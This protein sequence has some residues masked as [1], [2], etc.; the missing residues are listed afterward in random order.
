MSNKDYAPNNKWTLE[1]MNIIAFLLQLDVG[2]WSAWTWREKS[3]VAGFAI[4][5]GISSIWSGVTRL[6]EKNFGRTDKT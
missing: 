4:D 2:W 6:R 3:M 5:K 1:V